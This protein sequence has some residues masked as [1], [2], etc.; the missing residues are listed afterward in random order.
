MVTNMRNWI[1][2]KPIQIV[3]LVVLAGFSWGILLIN[4]GETMSDFVPLPSKR[5]KHQIPEL[6]NFRKTIRI[7]LAAGEFD[8]LIQAKPD[9][10]T[11]ELSIKRYPARQERYYIVQFDGPL[12]DSQKYELEDIGAQ[13][14]DYLPDFSFIVN[15][16]DTVHAMVQSMDSV[17]WIGT[18]QPA[19]KIKPTITEALSTGRR[20]LGAEY[21]VTLFKGENLQ[22]V[23]QQ[24]EQLGGEVL[25]IS[26][27]G[28]RR[29]I[30]IRLNVQALDF[31][32]AIDGVKWIEPAPL[33]KL[34]NDVASGI[35]GVPNVWNNRNLFGSNQV[36]AVADSGLDRG[37]ADPAN[38]HDDFEDGSGN[39]RV[40][41]IFDRVGDGAGDVNSGHGTH[42]T[43]S[44]LGNGAISGSDPNNHI[45]VNS[46]AGMA[47]EA[48]L[49]FQALEDIGEDLTGIPLDLG[50]LF[51]QAYNAGAMIH[52]NSWGAPAAGDYTSFSEEVDQ[53]VWDN[54]NFLILFAAGNEG[55]DADGDGVIDLN[56]MQTPATAK[57]C[58]TV[59]A[60]ESIRVGTPPEPVYDFWG[61]LWPI[62]YPTN[63]IK[64]D[65]VSDNESGM[66]AF[67]SRGP[68][69]DGRFKPDLVAPG[70]N[71]IS[72]KS[73]LATDLWGSGGLSSLGLEDHYIFCGGTSMSTPLVAGAATLVR[74][75][76]TDIESITP[77]AALIKATLLNG[78]A[79]ITPGQYGTGASQEIPNPPRPNNVEGRGR[80]DLENSIFPGSLKYED[81]AGGLTTNNSVAYDFTV[82]DGSE[83]LK[84]TLVWS[85]YPGS[86]VAFGGLVN[87]LDF[88]IIDPSGTVYYPKNASQ[89][90]ETELIIYDDGLPEKAWTWTPGNRVGVRFT[91]TSYPAKLDKAI[92]ALASF[93][94]S[95]PNTFS[96]YVYNG[97]N[98][99]GPQNVLASGTTTIRSSGWHVVDLSDFDLDISSGDFFLAI[100]LNADLVWFD[101]DTSPR[102][103]S[104]DYAD[105]AWSKWT[106]G[107]YLF[108]AAVVTEDNVTSYDRANN[109][110]GVDI[111]NP[112]VGLYSIYVEGHNVPQGPQPYALVVSS[113]NLSNLTKRFPPISPEGV[114]AFAVSSADIEL[115]WSDRSTTE[116]GFKIEKKI[117][118]GGTYSQID[119]VGADITDYTE[120]GQND[121]TI[122][123]YRVRAYNTEGNSSYFNETNVTI[124][125]A[126]S[127]LS[128]AAVSDSRINLSWSDNSSYELGFEI[129]RRV[130]E[131]VNHSWIATVDA[132]MTSYMD[133]HLSSSTSH[134]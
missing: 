131:N 27:H 118:H 134:Y 43:G 33:W 9:K 4:T 106:N 56:S 95:Y 15:M 112:A 12:K 108:R 121:E 105:G 48:S 77:S 78:A 72:T 98:S 67:S 71:I 54:K 82:A 51:S 127:D 109:V 69:L 107:N 125:A 42:V 52:T 111:N 60:S 8:P 123:F 119:T 122:Y 10:M 110:V 120:T 7:R 87:D 44:A 94:D 35:I 113:G 97:S 96:F 32:T 49:V 50:E 39:T 38:L 88:S 13:V 117:G 73:S 104:W 102:G 20:L 70:T 128:A 80:V 23:A 75:F 26:S 25:D 74:E 57:N 79:M 133:T 66:A 55:V 126:P 129:W 11:T 34:T 16:D 76:Y 90:G 61:T 64:S 58:I 36:V 116:S 91:P 62:D 53:F 5:V 100:Q 30:K 41:Q 29:K 24:I 86:P 19:Y 28:S 22:A 59:G 101:D 115:T 103:R 130:G 18:Y 37:Q 31:V 2:R 132:D 21:I 3:F 99:T 83:P 114:T 68:C 46:Y 84:A 40:L 6:K 14:F 65:H 89:N 85:D 1:L 63:P 47:P 92:F 81:E 45:Y 93:N 17:R 124:I